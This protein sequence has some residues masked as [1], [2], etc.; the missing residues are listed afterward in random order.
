MYL[1]LCLQPSLYKYLKLTT[2]TIYLGSFTSFFINGAL[3]LKGR[4]GGIENISCFFIKKNEEVK[5]W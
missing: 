2:C 5:E 4:A 1:W 3:L